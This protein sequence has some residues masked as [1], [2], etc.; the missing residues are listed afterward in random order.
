MSLDFALLGNDGRP[1]E[2][3]AL[4]RDEHEG[5]LRVAARGGL[6]AILK[7]HDYYEDVDFLPGELSGLLGDLRTAASSDGGEAPLL[8]GI[9]PTLVDLVTLAMAKGIG[10]SVLAD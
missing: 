1:A 7:M 8:A 4:T 9:L 5:L 2:T 3:V 10:V 6:T